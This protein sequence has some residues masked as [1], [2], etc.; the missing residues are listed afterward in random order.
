MRGHRLEVVK[1]GEIIDVYGV[2]SNDLLDSAMLRGSTF[3]ATLT[4]GDIVLD[5]AKI[6]IQ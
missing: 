6:N 2:I 1:A 4:I 3:L 5:Q